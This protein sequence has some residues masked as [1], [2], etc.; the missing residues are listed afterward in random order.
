[1]LPSLKENLLP[2]PDGMFTVSVYC[3]HPV[4]RTLWRIHKPQTMRCLMWRERRGMEVTRVHVDT[5][6]LEW[7]Y[8]LIPID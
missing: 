6:T 1:M 7:L 4:P 8:L 2:S 5:L 3:Q